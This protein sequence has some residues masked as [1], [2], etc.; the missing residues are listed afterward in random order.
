MRVN[1]VRH[2]LQSSLHVHGYRYSQVEGHPTI[3]PTLHTYI[4]K[5]LAN[6]CVNLRKSDHVW[7][8]KLLNTSILFLLFICPINQNERNV[9][10]VNADFHNHFLNHKIECIANRHG[11]RFKWNALSTDIIHNSIIGIVCIRH[12]FKYTL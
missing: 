5:T 12:I 7:I 2:H 4:N 11:T 6:H 9:L 1:Q 3:N 10:F 8:Y